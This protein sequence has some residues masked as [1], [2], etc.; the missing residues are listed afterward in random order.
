VHG[1]HH[2]LGHDDD[3]NGR[4]DGKPAGHLLRLLLLMLLDL[5]ESLASSFYTVCCVRAGAVQ[6]IFLYR[7]RMPC[8][9]Y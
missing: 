8:D 7:W 4:A 9:C 1:Q 2:R 5:L 6:V 3:E